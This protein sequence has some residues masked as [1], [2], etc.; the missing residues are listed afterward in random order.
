MNTLIKAILFGAGGYL[1]WRTGI[2]SSVSGGII[3]SPVT[4][5]APPAGAAP[6]AAGPPAF[7]S[8]AVTGQ[9]VQAAAILDYQ[10]GDRSNLLSVT[11][12]VPSASWDAWNYFL[13]AQTNF[14]DL[15]DYTTVTGQPN[16]G[17]AL[18]FAQYWQLISPW[19]TKNKGMTGIQAWR[20]NDS[21][22]RPWGLNGWSGYDVAARPSSPSGLNGWVNSFYDRKT[23][24]NLFYPNVRKWGF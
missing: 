16:T 4:G 8:L 21:S 7:N 22:A 18:T 14:P 19:L 9:R 2:L 5:A 13:N 23:P 11:D 6:A 10:H 17:Q 1:L 12:G 24:H 3:P 20:G 15:P